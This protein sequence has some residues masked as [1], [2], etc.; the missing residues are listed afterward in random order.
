MFCH[1]CGKKLPDDAAFCPYCGTKSAVLEG[2]AEEAAEAIAVA[3][4]AAEEVTIVE[5][6]I[7]EEA[8]AVEEAIAEEAAAV[9]EAVAEEVAAAEEA[10]A[11]VA[12][13]A[14]ESVSEEVSEEP[15]A[16]PVETPEAPAAS[17]ADAAANASDA[18]SEPETRAE[19]DI[20][21]ETPAAEPENAAEPA[22]E[23]A[24]AP[25]KKSK[26]PII[27]AAV[28]ALA[29]IGFL[30]YNNLPSTK[31]NKHVKAAD[32]YLEKGE[33]MQ[34]LAEADAVAEFDPQNPN[35]ARFEYLAYTGM[36]RDM[37]FD[38]DVDAAIGAYRN[39]SSFLK[40]SEAEDEL[41]NL[42]ALRTE[43]DSQA[44][45]L[46]ETGSIA[47]A[48][49]LLS[50]KPNIIPGAKTIYE[51]EILAAYM[52]TVFET[53]DQMAQDGNYEEAVIN[54]ELAADAVEP[55]KGKIKDHIVQIY[56]DVADRLIAEDDE[57]GARAYY[58]TL[59]QLP[60]NYDVTEIRD[61][62]N[63]YIEYRNELRSFSGFAEL[64]ASYLDDGDVDGALDF[65][66]DE[67]TLM[68][69]DYYELRTR[70]EKDAPL[71]VA[72]GN[73][74]WKVGLYSGF[75]TAY[76]YYGQYNEK[77]QRNGKGYWLYTGGTLS[78]QETRKCAYGDWVGDVP[79][80]EMENLVK[81]VY[82]D[83]DPK[84]TKYVG[85]VVNGLFDGELTMIY[86]EKVTLY[87][88]CSN[89][90]IKILATTDPNGKSG[91]VIAFT[92]DRKQWLSNE[93][94]EKNIYGLAGY[95]DGTF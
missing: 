5:E 11:E 78:G 23:P 22:A 76:I 61:R 71:I 1:K 32:A 86:N 75:Y 28:A 68:T 69:G 79:N 77:N 50:E 27:I 65:M 64:I 70:T 67:V 13:A 56:S 62:L 92:K 4:T 54:L 6:T 30:I 29:I 34:M 58:E 7:A 14:P 53:A 91:K 17:L 3:E 85:T 81:S 66:F 43:V 8:A 44:A 87:G 83:E 72:A 89:G 48:V 52:D 82:R 36:A 51:D 40:N 93:D 88:E 38:G 15:A 47:D 59:K 26:L 35:L 25:K 41:Y 39:L 57:I 80:G 94:A 19:T 21:A 12:E 2:A 33:Y 63:V 18:P 84:V 37:I 73:Q 95:N 60:G 45:R 42:E 9:E 31:I 49:N 16:E 20:P 10:V 24:E 55:Y 90:K 46:L 74:G